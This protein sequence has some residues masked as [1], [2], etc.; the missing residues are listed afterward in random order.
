MNVEG[1]T[2]PMIGELDCGWHI[3]HTLTESDKRNCSSNVVIRG[4]LAS[5]VPIISPPKIS[6]KVFVQQG[7]KKPKDWEKF[8]VKHFVACGSGVAS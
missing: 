7:A 2:P 1:E 4:E 5:H 3:T 6:F 8:F